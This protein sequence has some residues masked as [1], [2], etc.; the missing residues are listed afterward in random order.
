MIFDF[1][2]SAMIAAAGGAL[3]LAACGDNNNDSGATMATV[4]GVAVKESRVDEQYSQI[5]AQM[6]QGREAD[7]KRQ[8]LDRVIDQE[9]IA[10]E[11]K[12]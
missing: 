10:Q 4:N 5:P 2:K 9:L 3:L 7:V 1:R 6:V 11:A 12:R 8:I